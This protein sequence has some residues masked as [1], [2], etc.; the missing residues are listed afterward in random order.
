MPLGSPSSASV[1]SAAKHS[2]I[3]AASTPTPAG[4]GWRAHAAARSH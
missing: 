4:P 1:R 3:I 2:W